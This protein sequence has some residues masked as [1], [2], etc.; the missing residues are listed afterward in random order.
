[1]D[2]WIKKLWY[3]YTLEHFSV[4]KKKE[5]LPFATMD[6]K[7]IMLSEIRERWIPYDFFFMW[8][9]KQNKLKQTKLMDTKKR[10]VVARAGGQEVG[11]TG[12]GGQR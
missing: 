4:I 1:M 10:L 2:E 7:G 8:N 11:E 5:T 12:E 6:L 3:L 9:L